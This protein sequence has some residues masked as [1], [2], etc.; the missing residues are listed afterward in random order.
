ML[1]KIKT[2]VKH[3][4]LYSLGNAFNKLTGFILLPLYTSNF[5]VAV[6]GLLALFDT[7]ADFLLISSS[8]G[9]MEGFKRWYWDQEKSGKQKALFFTVLFFTAIT[10]IFFLILAYF[11]INKYGVHIFGLTID[12]KTLLLFLGSVLANVF[13]QRLLILLRVR[14]MVVNNVFYTL[15]SMLLTLGGT[16][17]FILVLNWGIDA[18]FIS[19]FIGQ[20]ATLLLLLP[21]LIKNIQIKFDFS[22]LK[23]MLAYSWPLAL[24]ASLGLIFTF[25]DRWI[26]QGMKSLDVVGNYSLAYR[27]A[28]V[29]KL[30]VVHSFAQAFTY[31]YFRQMNNARH[32]RFFSKFTTYFAYIIVLMGMAIVMFSKEIIHLLARNADYYD[33]YYILPFL[34]LA[35][36]FSGMRQMLTLPL[37]K[38][39]KTKII[40]F[41][42]ICA[43]IVNIGLNILFI[44]LWG[45][46]G[47]AIATGISHLIPVIIYYF[48]NKKITDFNYE[49]G[50]IILLFVLGIAFSVTGM[51]LGNITL[52]YRLILKIILLAS[53]PLI[54]KLFGFY[55]DI[56]LVRIAQIVKKWWNPFK[57]GQYLKKRN[58]N[59]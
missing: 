58:D 31:I 42:S 27:I 37:S 26:L 13:L 41:V 30:I 52:A 48:V 11:I 40:S 28:N 20:L 4:V 1:D 7:I 8:F 35:V 22:I 3:S 17:Y 39:K 10:T 5:S 59:S 36:S 25:S 33:S 55:E 56:E 54:L 2:T 16:I 24:S 44:P 14:Q 12:N 53:F 15:I 34:V 32:Y 50:K 51:Q 9:I 47:A 43:G 57:W 49:T 18:V 46:S 45:A 21:T 6:Y 29:I 19:R 23:S 38:Y